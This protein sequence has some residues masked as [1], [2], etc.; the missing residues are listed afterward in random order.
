MLQIN[1]IKI[2]A[3]ATQ[4]LKQL[5]ARTGLTPNILSRLAICLSLDQPRNRELLSMDSNGQ[6]FNNYTLFGQWEGLIISLVKQYLTDFTK[7]ASFTEVEII[8]EIRYHLMRGTKW[9]YSRIKSLESLSSIV[10]KSN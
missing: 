9:L 2:S 1:R 5:K 3:E 7:K 8:E 6:E 4:K 10:I